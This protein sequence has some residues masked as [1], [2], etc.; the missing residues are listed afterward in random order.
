MAVD[1]A[2]RMAVGI[3]GYEA[4]DIAGY[5][6][7]GSR[8][9][10]SSTTINPI[11]SEQPLYEGFPNA[12]VISITP[13]PSTPDSF[14]VFVRG[15]IQTS[16]MLDP[17]DSAGRRGDLSYLSPQ[18]QAELGIS[19]MAGCISGDTLRARVAANAEVTKGIFAI[20]SLTGD[21]VRLRGY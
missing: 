4:A 1:M 8:V 20:G 6:A 12:E 10:N 15:Y 21:S 13:H 9:S 7:G 17:R 11:V 14:E 19:H 18:I 2:V 5:I 16:R 3:A